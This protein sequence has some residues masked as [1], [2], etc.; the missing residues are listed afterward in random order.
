MPE[1]A[2]RDVVYVEVGD[3]SPGGSVSH[4]DD[5]LRAVLGTH[6]KWRYTRKD[7]TPFLT[8]FHAHAAPP[9]LHR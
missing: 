9:R 5:D 8:E 3:R 4:P 6:S 7:G 1:V 2:E